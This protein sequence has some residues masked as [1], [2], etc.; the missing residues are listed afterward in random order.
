MTNS[1]VAVVALDRE[2]QH[3]SHFVAPARQRDRVLDHVDED[4][5]NL[6][7]PLGGAAPEQFHRHLD[8][9]IDLDLLADHR[10]EAVVDEAVDEVPR[11]IHR[12]LEGRDRPSP[13]ALVDG[14]VFL[15]AANREGRHLVEEERVAVIVEDHNGDVGLVPSH[16][17]LSRDVTVEERLPVGRVAQAPVEGHPDR[18]NMRRP[19]PANQLRHVTSFPV[20]R[21]RTNRGPCRPGAPRSR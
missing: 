3:P 7:G 5:H 9:V 13:P 11:E 19:E 12:A 21:A 20:G 6:D 18:G 2:A 8:A 4:R 16:P 10:V 17:F 15:R 1:F 14:P